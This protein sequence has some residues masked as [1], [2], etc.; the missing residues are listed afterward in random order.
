MNKKLIVGY[1][2]NNVTNIKTLL[3][4]T[5]EE[6]FDF[7]ICPIFH[8]RYDRFLSS[9]I[10]PLKRNYPSTRSDVLLSNNDWNSL[11]I[12]KISLAVNDLD[13]P[14]KLIRDRSFKMIKQ[15]L[16]WG[17]HLGLGSVVLPTPSDNCTNY[18]LCINSALQGLRMQCLVNIPLVSTK[19]MVAEEE[20]S[21]ILEKE[22]SVNERPKNDTWEW[23]NSFRSYCGHHNN[24]CVSLEI[25][26]D[27]PDGE[28][29][30]RWI[31]EPVRL[32]T[33]PTSIFVLGRNGMP[34]L[35]QLHKEFLMALF[36]HSQVQ[37]VISG[38]PKHQ[39]G[40]RVYVNY[41]NYLRTT[42]VPYTE[43]EKFEYPYRDYLQV[44]LQPLMD[45]L[46]SQTYEVFEQDPVK[47]AK[48]ELAVYQA[49]LDIPESQKDILIMVVGAGR[50]PL[51]RESISASKRAN[52]KSQDFCS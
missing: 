46:E 27:L 16:A 15:E 39:E 4:T 37:Y 3:D 12:G 24:L 45:N 51:V 29:L 6:G 49:L 31:A 17:S 21:E 38:Q 2:T 7:I 41:L 8:P 5:E 44:P 48:Y 32:V 26:E 10:F 40:L 1:D 11:V 30:K 14:H 33:V 13:S 20:E 34:E 43:Q 47:Y 19:V 36:D 28:A 50:G 35:P 22:L 23:W 25:T 18:A 52:K 42:R 9:D